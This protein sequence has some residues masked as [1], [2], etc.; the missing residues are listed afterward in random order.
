MKSRI[1]I[2]ATKKCP[3]NRPI[4]SIDVDPNLHRGQVP[5][6]PRKAPSVD[7]RHKVINEAGDNT[8]YVWRL[9]PFVGYYPY[10]AFGSSSLCFRCWTKKREYECEGGNT[11][12]IIDSGLC[13]ANT[14][15]STVLSAEDTDIEPRKPH[16]DVSMVNPWSSTP[17]I[18]CGKAK[19]N[20]DG[21][22]KGEIKIKGKFFDKHCDSCSTL[23][24]GSGLA[25]RAEAA[26]RKDRL[27]YTWKRNP[28]FITHHKGFE[29][30]CFRCW[31][32]DHGQKYKCEGGLPGS[33]ESTPIAIEWCGPITTTTAIYADDTTTNAS[34]YTMVPTPVA[35][36]TVPWAQPID[37][38]QRDE[39]HDDIVMTN[40]WS[41]TPSLI[42]G[43]AGLHNTRD[44]AGKIEIY[45]QYPSFCVKGGGRIDMDIS[46]PALAPRAEADTYLNEVYTWKHNPW[47]E[48]HYRFICFRCWIYGSGDNFKCEGRWN[49]KKPF[50]DESCG[51]HPQEITPTCVD[52]TTAETLEG[53]VAP[54]PVVRANGP[55]AETPEIEPRE[56]NKWVIM[57]N[58]WDPS[59]E[60]LKLIC[61]EA[62]FHER[63][64]DKGRI[65]IKGKFSRYCSLGY[66][67]I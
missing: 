28:F 42:C 38:E 8:V 16:R 53:F 15:G 3:K 61:G 49:T 30:Y 22:D 52:A 58:P 60:R 7:A 47:P 64:G 63:H 54:T 1:E 50:S 36:L 51:A 56:K 44:D 19:L 45:G 62:T 37:L 13:G 14:L 43:K 4:I 11:K 57:R 34:V 9:N 41:S 65:E 67:H 40:P 33:L 21:H 17:H 59:G 31:L 10:S 20:D 48:D 32:H 29:T 25:P 6:H 27:V 35:T 18:I 12:R 46:E 39:D 2:K 23:F 55:R 24:L 26:D 5:K 66:E